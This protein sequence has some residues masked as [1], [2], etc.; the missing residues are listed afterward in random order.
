MS[1]IGVL[2]HSLL[3]GT[4]ELLINVLASGVLEGLFPEYKPG[5]NPWWNLLEGGFEIALY[6]LIAGTA[7]NAL[8]EL[9]GGTRLARLPYGSLLMFWLLDN[10][11]LK[12]QSFVDYVSRRLN[13]R[14]ARFVGDL[15]A[16]D[17]MED[18]G[19][20]ME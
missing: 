19:D 20:K 11:V 13:E 18:E 4:G 12:V 14:R 16:M 2:F 10:A 8:G 1:T 6:L 9:V 15:S 7:S 3:K 17:A 5:S